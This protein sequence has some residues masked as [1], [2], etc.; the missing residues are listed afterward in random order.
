LEKQIRELREG[1]DISK[2]QIEAIDKQIKDAHNK[3]QQVGNKS[4]AI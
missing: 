1:K 4:Q 2:S 3:H